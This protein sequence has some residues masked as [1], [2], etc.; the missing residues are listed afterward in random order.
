MLLNCD[1][2]ESFGHWKIGDDAKVIGNIDLANIACGFHA[3]DP[4][5]MDTA[6]RIAI[7][8]KVIIGA[9]PGHCDLIGFGRR[10]INVSPKELRASLSYQIGALKEIAQVAGGTVSY[11]K[12][13]GA[14]YNSMMQDDSL[15]SDIM[16]IVA[17]SLPPP[18]RL[19]IL[20]TEKAE[21]H[22]AMAES[23]RLKLWFEAFADRLYGDDGYLVDRSKKGSLFNSPEQ[24]ENQIK[25]I[26]D[27]GSVNSENNKNL[28]IEA[29]TICI[30]SDNEPS[31]IEIEKIHKLFSKNRNHP[32]PIGDK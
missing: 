20:Y 16:E 17:Y 1:V 23:L 25:S 28:K 31:I 4:V 21:I 13:H 18:A 6:V 29:D 27:E 30:H 22:K 24:I 12:P 8:N 10:S 19:I 11:V 3:G 9:H 14:L 26:I 5:I 15:L 2:G 32:C 7:K